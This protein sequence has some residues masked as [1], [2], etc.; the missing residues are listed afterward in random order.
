MPEALAVP[1]V[2]PPA[3]PFWGVPIPTSSSAQGGM[4]QVQSY[5]DITN[6]GQ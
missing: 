3:D 5:S 6:R 4:V 2:N 1:P